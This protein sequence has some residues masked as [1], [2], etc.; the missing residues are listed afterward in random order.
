M[1]HVPP[2][3]PMVTLAFLGAALLIAAGMAGTL[4]GALSKRPP[5]AIGSAS[6]AAAVAI[7]YGLAWAG[8]AFATHEHILAPGQTKY[9]CEI[10]CHLAYSLTRVER[11]TSIGAAGG[12]APAGGSFLVVT[13]KTWF[14]PTTISPRRPLDAR[15]WPNPRE[16]FV[17]DR[18]R[19]RYRAIP[20]ATA[21]LAKTGRA[22]TPMTEPLRPGESYETTLVFDVPADAPEP[23]LF[24]GNIP[25]ESAFIIGHESSPLAR[26][27]W[28]SLGE[29]VSAGGR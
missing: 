5:L 12:H 28:F 16:I 29:R 14:D 20:G 9:F 3:A 1:V 8:A 4:Y 23:R 13:M 18:D 25:A 27:T 19:R 26:K 24:V 7:A 17:M 2:Q 15:L 10:D 6:L 11:M 21:A 22:S